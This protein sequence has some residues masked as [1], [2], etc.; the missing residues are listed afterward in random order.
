VHGIVALALGAGPIGLATGL[1][2]TY[3]E[4]DA[5]CEQIERLL[6]VH[7][8]RR[9]V[10]RASAGGEEGECDARKEPPV[11]WRVTFHGRNGA[12]KMFN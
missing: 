1:L 10:E 7:L 5:I 3:C 12:R 2:G 9:R 11:V 8:D 4:L 6:L